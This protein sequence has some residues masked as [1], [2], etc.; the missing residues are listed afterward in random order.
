MTDIV[1]LK[2][3]NAHRWAAMHMKA[4]RIPAFDAAAKPFCAPDAKARYEGVTARL[5]SVGYGWRSRRIHRTS[6]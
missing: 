1:T 2:A 4:D 6:F 5:K 3:A